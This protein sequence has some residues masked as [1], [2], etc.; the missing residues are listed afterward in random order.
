MIFYQLEMF[1]LSTYN[2]SLST[3]Q[4]GTVHKMEAISMILVYYGLET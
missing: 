1:H 3:I 2:F 4:K